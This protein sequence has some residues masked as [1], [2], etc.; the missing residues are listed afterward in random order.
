[1]VVGSTALVSGQSF[2]AM[3]RFAEAIKILPNSPNVQ[4]VMRQGL[5][6]L[7]R[8]T[9]R[10]QTIVTH[11]DRVMTSA[12]FSKDGSRVVTASWAGTARIWQTDTGAEL[13]KLEGQTGGV[14]FAAFSE[15][16]SRV[17]TISFDNAAWV[18]KTDTGSD[19]D[20]QGPHGRVNSAAFDNDGRRV[21]TASDDKTARIWQTDTGK[22]V[23]LNGHTGAVNSAAFSKDG[24]RVVT[25]SNDNTGA[26]LANRHG[27]IRRA[28]RP[29]GPG[30]FGRVP[31][32]RQ[33]R[34]HRVE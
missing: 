29:H 23:E 19:R 5:G 9:P 12:Y 24:K 20:T 17:V 27:Q 7:A 4:D 8:E 25:A 6:F 1:M 28:Q 2:D 3:H 34:C 30:Q 26:D 13:A 33:L 14:Y 16:G 32:E 11:P 18:W 15:D 21:V 22:S 31:L 10:L